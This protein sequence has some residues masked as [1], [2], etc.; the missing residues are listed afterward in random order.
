MVC[1]PNQ[2]KVSEWYQRD[3]CSQTC[4]VTIQASHVASEPKCIVQP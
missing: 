1:I 2:K 4:G 3:A